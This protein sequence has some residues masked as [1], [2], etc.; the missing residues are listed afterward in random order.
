MNLLMNVKK[1][2]SITLMKH[3]KLFEQMDEEESWWEKE[4]PF[5]NLGPPLMLARARGSLNFYI[6][7]E[8]DNNNIRLWDSDYV[9]SKISYSLTT[10]PEENRRILY[11]E[12][13]ST[14][15]TKCL[16]KDLPKEIKDRLVFDE[17]ADYI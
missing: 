2:R 7:K 10:R 13:E 8:I 9:H 6:V 3:I 14:K 1:N 16:F 5:D 15:L 12:P 17:N 4:S 11:Y